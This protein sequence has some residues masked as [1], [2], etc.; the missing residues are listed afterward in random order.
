MLSEEEDIRRFAAL[1]TG[2]HGA[3]AIDVVRIH[4]DAAFR[5][6]DIADYLDWMEVLGLIT[7]MLDPERL[8]GRMPAASKN[9]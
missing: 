4:A 6:N 7:T 8:S 2:R 9:S 5:R 1:L 3:Q